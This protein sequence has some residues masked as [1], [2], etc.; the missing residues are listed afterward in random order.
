MPTSVPEPVTV[1]EPAPVYV[2]EL[3]TSVKDSKENG[4]NENSKIFVNMQDNPSTDCFNCPPQLLCC[5][6]IQEPGKETS[7]YTDLQIMMGIV[8]KYL[9]VMNIILIS[10]KVLIILMWL[11]MLIW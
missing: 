9:K 2:P 8:M 10:V 7:N 6:S 4:S 11:L 5:S 3:P 1:P